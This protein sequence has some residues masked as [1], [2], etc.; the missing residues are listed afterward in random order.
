MRA[1]LLL[2]AKQLDGACIAGSSLALA[3][4]RRMECR[5]CGMFLHGMSPTET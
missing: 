5:M 2:D 3:R 1:A 4:V